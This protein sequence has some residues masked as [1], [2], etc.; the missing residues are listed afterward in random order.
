[1]YSDDDHDDVITTPPFKASLLTVLQQESDGSREMVAARSAG[2]TVV[3]A[4][5]GGSDKGMRDTEKTGEELVEGFTDCH[6]GSTISL[7]T[8]SPSSSPP[9][10]GPAG[11]PTLWQLS[12]CHSGTSVG[13]EFY[14]PALSDVF[15]PTKVQHICTVA[16]ISLE[17]ASQ[18]EQNGANF[19]FIA[20]SVLE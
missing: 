6:K 13:E 19:S 3:A 11:Y 17:R 12:A 20:P 16:L 15:S 14:V 4:E 8:P 5:A 1:M 2:E 7:P 9:G 18:E 10:S